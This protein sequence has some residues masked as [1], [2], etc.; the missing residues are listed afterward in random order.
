MTRGPSPSGEVDDPRLDPPGVGVAVAELLPGRGHCEFITPV[1]S[2]GWIV[3]TN[4]YAP[5]SSAGHVVDLDGSR[6]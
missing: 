1:I 4:A 3:Q 5:A 6:R 2:P